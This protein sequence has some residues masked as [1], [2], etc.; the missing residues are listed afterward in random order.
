MKNNHAMRTKVLVPLIQRAKRAFLLSGTPALS[1]PLELYTQ[2][3]ALQPGLWGDE[4][5]FAKRYCKGKKGAYRSEYNGASNTAELQLMLLQSIMIRRLKKDILKH[6]PE[7]L[8]HVTRVSVIDEKLQEEL[9]ELVR[10][11]REREEEREQW[12][13]HQRNMK[14]SGL[15]RYVDSDD[16]AAER[17]KAIGD[18]LPSNELNAA[19]GGAQEVG[20]NGLH[21]VE[22]ESKRNLML[23]LY[24]K[25][26]LAKLPGVLV[27]LD[28]FLDGPI[29]G[30]ILIFAHHH[31]VLDGIEAHLKARG[32][33]EVIR[34]DGKTGSNEKFAR[35]TRFQ[36]NPK[37]RVA[38]LAITAA[39]VAV[40]L[41]AASTVFFAEM[42]WNPGALFQAEDRAHRIGQTATVN[43]HYFKAAGTIDDFLY[44]LLVKKAKV[45][46]D[47]GVGRRQV[48]DT[49]DAGAE[50]T[51]E[52]IHMDSDE[53]AIYKDND[54]VDD[55]DANDANGKDVSG[56][57][58]NMNIDGNTDSSLDEKEN[59]NNETSEGSQIRNGLKRKRS[60]IE[61]SV[62]GEPHKGND[63]QNGSD[64]PDNAH[65]RK[66]DGLEAEVDSQ[67]EQDAEVIE[68]IAKELDLQTIDRFDTEGEAPGDAKKVKVKKDGDDDDDD[69]DNG[70]GGEDGSD[71]G[72]GDTSEPPDPLALLYMHET[73]KLQGMNPI[74]F[75]GMLNRINCGYG[76]A[77]TVPLGANRGVSGYAT[78]NTSGPVD[79]VKGANMNRSSAGS[80]NITV[81][82]DDDE[83]VEGT[84][85][86]TG[87][88]KAHDTAESA[89]AKNPAGFT[90]NP[91]KQ[92][93][94]VPVSGASLMPLASSSLL[95]N[96]LMSSNTASEL[97]VPMDC[98]AGIN[99]HQASQP[100][101][102]PNPNTNPIP[103]SDL[104][105]TNRQLNGSMDLANMVTAEASDGIGTVSPSKGVSHTNSTAGGTDPPN[106]LP[107][108][109]IPAVLMS[110]SENGVFAGQYKD[111]NGEYTQAFINHMLEL[112][113]NDDLDKPSTLHAEAPVD[114]SIHTNGDI[115]CQA[116]ASKSLPHGGLV[117]VM[118]AG[119]D[120]A[121]SVDSEI[122]Q[123]PDP[124]PPPVVYD[125][126]DDSDSD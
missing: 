44:P 31:S 90:I 11:L 59:H 98:E 2:L 87:E 71:K 50:L 30:K 121:S 57:E 83:S 115:E 110:Q 12:R 46:E 3:H 6:L 58:S 43:I 48:F 17:E 119:C 103:V 92:F 14:K 75:T 24:R 109:C 56:S 74:I 124:R 13:K 66:D 120:D 86:K 60:G 38:V 117:N 89:T 64:T 118:D 67:A 28:K 72:D 112:A 23:E 93:L 42:F 18:G 100:Q 34:I 45:L 61:E 47:V 69:D 35:V 106:D 10:T 36:N 55:A 4:K 19:P 84:S 62:R 95:S 107:H 85:T 27:H 111:T 8:R 65:A 113:K 9:R 122:Q 101:A 123:V 125:L 79:L 114:P 96:G 40:T 99:Q 1:R 88:D 97:N 63:G 20:K 108:E 82:I 21:A 78:G 37:C 70:D 102:S 52:D 49:K 116:A 5:A 126:L 77:P 26:G 91:D 39:G 53:E 32:E 7:K 94:T 22:Q 73:G 33:K 16:L 81:I 105:I 54:K 25:S 80:S 76:V 68:R 15:G 29:S 104:S 51:G 41:T